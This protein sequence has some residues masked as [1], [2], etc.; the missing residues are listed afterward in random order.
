M[1]KYVYLLITV[2]LASCQAP[3]TSESFN[4]VSVDT[5]TIE[6][7]LRILAS[8]EFAGRMPFTEGETKTIL[9]LKEEFGKMGLKPGN[10]DSYFQEVPLVEITGTPS[11]EMVISG[12]KV[13]VRLKLKEEFVALTERVEDQVSLDNSGLVFAG[14]GIVAPE[15]GWNDY[16]GLDVKDKT[17]IVMVN[18]PGFTLGDTTFFKGEA[19]TYYGRWTYKYEEA[20]RQGAAGCLIIHETVP[21]GYPWAVVQ[22]GWSGANLSL[23]SKDDGY[24]LPVMGWISRDAAIRIFE[25]SKVDMRGFKEKARSADFKPIPLGVGAS[26]EVANKIKKDVS[27]NVLAMIPGTEKP[28]EY[29]IYSAHWDHLGVGAIIDGDSIN[30]GAHDNA[31][32]TATMMAIAEAFT[33]GKPPKRNIVFAVVTAEEQ[34]LLG[35][36][37]YAENPV[38]PVSKTVA[39]INLDGIW[40]HGPMK[41]VT[42]VGYGQS[43][44]D[45]I[46]EKVAKS[47]GRYVLPDQNAGKGLYFRSDHFSFAK[48]GVPALYAKGQHEHMTKGTGYFKEKYDGYYAV[49]YH[50]ALDNYVPEE[51]DY[52]G[53]ALDGNFLY[54]VGLE[55]ANSEEWPQW[56]EGSE[57]KS[58]REASLK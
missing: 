8:D 54:M 14:Y 17:V 18:D 23:D 34:G 36:K 44:L 27:R 26:V 13:E 53:M 45:E 56:K 48:V 31:S 2:L 41:D 20:A 51:W 35:S 1:K 28:D 12:G 24:R 9:Y 38:F 43:D 49:N 4:E 33:K 58:I 25:S 47:Q 21:A 46:A 42:V 39:N 19:M 40:H 22:G 29:V 15:Y 3:T 10:G 37:F 52:A 50:S 11:E 30:N 16:D 6:R 55:V 57:F 7:V 5:T 32:G